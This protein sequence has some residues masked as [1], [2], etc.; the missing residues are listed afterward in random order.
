[1]LAALVGL[2]LL[3]A[4]DRTELAYPRYEMS[5]FDPIC[6]KPADLDEIQMLNPEEWK[7]HSRWIDQEFYTVHGG[8]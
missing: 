5:A 6:P 1:M 3:L 7:R 2:G 4:D 8:G